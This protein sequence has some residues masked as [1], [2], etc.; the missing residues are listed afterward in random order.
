MRWIRRQQ[1]LAASARIGVSDTDIGIQEE[2]PPNVFFD[3]FVS[4]PAGSER[5]RVVAWG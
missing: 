4:W 1:T 2:E 3:R 5:A